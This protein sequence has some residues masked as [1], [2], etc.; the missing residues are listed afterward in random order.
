MRD[1]MH[2]ESLKMFEEI[3]TGAKRHRGK[4]V[5]LFEEEFA[6]AMGT[7]RAVAM[8]AAMSVLHCA[9]TAA[10]AGPGDEVIVDPVMVFGAVAVMYADAIPVF[11]DIKRHSM[12]V[13]PES[14]RSRITE[15][16]KAIICTHCYGNPCEMDKIVEIARKHRLFVIED[17]AH[18]TLAEYKGKRI[19]AWGDLGSFSFCEKHLGTGDGGMAVMDREDVARHLLDRSGP[20]FGSVAHH[21]AWNYRMNEE[22]AAVG[23]PQLR[24]AGEIV[25]K[26]MQGAQHYNEAIAE[27][28]WLKTQEVPEGGKHAYLCWAGVFDG[29]KHGVKIEDFQK[30]A[31]DAGCALGFGYTKLVGYRH[32]AVKEYLAVGRGRGLGA[33]LPKKTANQEG[34]CPVAEELMGN[35]DIVTGFSGTNVDGARQNAD[36]LRKAIEAIG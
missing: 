33:R 23:L 21:R 25:G 32:P 13:D 29:R 27:C 11:A 15:R 8:N 9:V 1:P 10:G 31:K 18:A 14:I 35:G 34:S 7:K 28:P 4:Y 30:A 6:A 20:T 17:A 36:A 5:N 26:F 16:T 3:V 12:N 19:G 24:R 2:E 22:T